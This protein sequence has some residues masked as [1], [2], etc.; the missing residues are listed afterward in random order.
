MLACQGSAQASPEDPARF[1]Q[2][3][4]HDA[5]AAAKAMATQR[6]AVIA[7]GA[8]GVVLLLS[9]VD[10]PVTESAVVFAERMPQ[11]MRRVLH[12]A[13][14]VKVVRPLAVGFFLGSLASGSERLQDAAFTSVQAIIYSNLVSNGLKLVAGRARPGA[15]MGPGSFSPFSGR[16]SFPS[17]HATTVFAFTVPWLAY[18]PR[19]ETYA[20]FL[21]GIGTAFVRIADNHHWLTDVTTG[22]FIGATTGYL[23][24]RRHLRLHTHLRLSPVVT[25][26]GAGIRA[27]VSL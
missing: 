10:Q 12:E 9:Q 17:G 23:L 13:G 4:V 1:A 5:V 11:R 20:F 18:Y 22:A 15:N 25:S 26:G 2:W 8:A 24:S 27:A 14:N 3:V 6:T 19:V 21:L 7:G 16:R